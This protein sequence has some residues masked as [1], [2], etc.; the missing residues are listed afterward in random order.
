M[1]KAKKTKKKLDK[2]TPYQV[3]IRI[4]Q[5]ASYNLVDKF[6]ISTNNYKSV[7]TPILDNIK[8]GSTSPSVYK[9]KKG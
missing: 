8:S 4:K 5:G 7:L 3:L 9:K 2:S 6:D 1:A